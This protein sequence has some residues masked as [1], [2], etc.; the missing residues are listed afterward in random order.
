MVPK[1][2]SWFLQ[3][4][5]KTASYPEAVMVIQ[6]LAFKTLII[7]YKILLLGKVLSSEY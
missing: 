5:T 2:P 1:T 3:L 4:V 7:V 6:K